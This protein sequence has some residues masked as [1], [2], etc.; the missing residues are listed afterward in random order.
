MLPLTVGFLIA[1]PISGYLSDRFGSRPFATGGMLAGRSPSSCSSCCRSTSTTGVRPAAVLERPG[2]GRASPPQPGRGHEQPAA[3]TPRGRLGHELDLPELGPGAVDR[4]LLHPDDHRP[5]RPRCPPR[6][7]T[8][9]SPRASPADAAA[10]SSHLPPVSTL[11]AAFLGY[12]PIQH[13]LGRPGPRPPAAGQAAVA[14]RAEFFPTSSPSRSSRACTRPSTSPCWP[15][16]WRPGRRGCGA[17]STST[18]TPR[19]AP[20]TWWPTRSRTP[21]STRGRAGRGGRP[22]RR[23][24]PG[25]RQSPARHRPG[26]PV[27]P[28]LPG[29]TALGAGD[30]DGPEEAPGS[31]V[32][33]ELRSSD[34]RAA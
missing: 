19:A 21:R 29:P 15:A 23:P 33:W 11:F 12:S 1:G 7:T 25:G 18:G 14:D 24:G 30:R 10:G 31:T 20:T 2:H 28:G 4:H 26:R 8:A 34:R 13:L 22:G 3:P 5:D 27:P 6:C 17:A 16:W 32:T 9:W